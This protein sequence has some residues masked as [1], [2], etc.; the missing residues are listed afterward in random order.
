MSCRLY[1]VQELQT[2]PRAALMESTPEAVPSSIARFGCSREAGRAPI[3]SSAC[4]P[5]DAQ[6]ERQPM[7]HTLRIKTRGSARRASLAERR[8]LHNFITAQKISGCVGAYTTNGDSLIACGRLLLGLTPTSGGDHGEPG[9]QQSL[10]S[11]F[12]WPIKPTA[13]G[14][15]HAVCPRST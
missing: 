14:S 5:R 9:L 4:G 12:R 3:D 15:R 7:H 6:R 8:I 2:L 11:A 13:W 10:A 1:C